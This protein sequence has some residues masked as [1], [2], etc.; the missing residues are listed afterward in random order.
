MTFI[1]RVSQDLIFDLVMSLE[2]NDNY[3][4]KTH[5]EECDECVRCRP[6]ADE[7]SQKCRHSTIEH[8][9]PNHL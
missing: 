4:S 8:R 1:H 2:I 6:A 3:I 5:L 9:R 7:E